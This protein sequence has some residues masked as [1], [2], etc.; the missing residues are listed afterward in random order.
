MNSL[1]LTAALFTAVLL[2]GASVSSF[3]QTPPVATPTTQGKGKTV[4]KADKPHLIP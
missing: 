3:A 2:A 1:R 4:G